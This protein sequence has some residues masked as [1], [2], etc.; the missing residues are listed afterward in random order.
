MIVRNH[1]TCCKQ[2]L[3]YTCTTYTIYIYVLPNLFTNI[4]ICTVYIDYTAHCPE[5]SLLFSAVL[6]ENDK[7]KRGKRDT[8]RNISSSTVS[9]FPQYF[10]LYCGNLGYF[11][12][13]VYIQSC[14][15]HYGRGSEF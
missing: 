11:L 7:K 2:L 4:F 12:D 8:K 14:P 9:R 15:E 3:C 1:R 5:G 6:H 10:M 13:S